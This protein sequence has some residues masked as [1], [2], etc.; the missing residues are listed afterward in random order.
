MPPLVTKCCCDVSLPSNIPADSTLGEKADATTSRRLRIAAILDEGISRF[1][2]QPS[3][4]QPRNVF[5][6]LGTMQRLLELPGRA[7]VIAIGGSDAARPSS[8]IQQAALA[9]ALRPQ[10]ADFGLQVS[11]IE[12]DVSPTSHFLQL[13]AERLVLAPQLVESVRKLWPAEDIQPVITYLANTISLGDLSIPYSTVTGV[14]STAELG[15]LRDPDGKPITLDEDEIALN[16]WAARRLSAQLGDKITIT[17]YEPETTHGRLVEKSTPPLTLKFIVP[18]KNDEGKLTAAA[19]PT[20][21]LRN[22]P[23]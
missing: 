10:L 22:Y 14:D 19:D 20:S 2:L 21:S 17:Y 13:S 9:K 1:G 5:V 8:A 4:L 6:A 3:Q 18:L 11:E 7:N 12:I 16:D 15:P 23:E